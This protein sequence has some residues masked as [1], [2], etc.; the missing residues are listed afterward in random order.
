[1]RKIPKGFIIL[2]F[3]FFFV[4]FPSLF[5]TNQY[6]SMFQT[7][8]I[9]LFASCFSALFYYMIFLGIKQ[10]FKFFKGKSENCTIKPDP[11]RDAVKPEPENSIS[12][13]EFYYDS[14]LEATPKAEADFSFDSTI[15]AADFTFSDSP[16]PL[17]ILLKSA[18][19][20]RQGLYPHEILMLTYAPKFKTFNNTF[21]GFWYWQYSVTDPQSILDSLF[22][23]GFIKTGDLRSSLEK[24]TVP[25]IKE[26]LKQIN[27]KVSGKKSELI[28]RLIKFGDF[29]TLNQKYL[30]RYYSLTSKGEQELQENQYVLYLHKNKRINMTVWEMNRRIAHTHRPYRDILWEYFNEQA[31][32]HLQN[33]NFGLYWCNC[34]N[35]YDFLMED[36]RSQEAFHILCELLLLELN[37]LDNQYQYL[38]E[39]EKTDPEY[40]LTTYE[41]KL[42]DLFPYE[43]SSLKI[44]PAISDWIAEMQITLA[45]DDNNYKKAILKELQEIHLPCR[46]FTDEE[47]VDI[48][49]ANIHHDIDTLTSIYKEAEKRQKEKL[50]EIQARIR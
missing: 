12:S 23:R 11:S 24:L 30:E 35:M 25:E 47:C 39:C 19:P 28:D 40:Y 36:D 1:M 26:E 9:S 45:L 13:K 7:F 44:P 10:L 38:L 3:L 8:L 33:L 5:L 16:T 50:K 21:Q 14:S 32:I 17:T 37:D 48:V 27:Q 46:I 31:S 41:S 22:D 34:L 6:S 20:S 15:S 49:I 43:E 4:L 18:T 29:T 42:K 2:F